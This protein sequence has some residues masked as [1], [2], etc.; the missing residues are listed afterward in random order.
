MPKAPKKPEF[1][2]SASRLKLYEGCSWQ[3]YAKYKLKLPDVSN[4]GSIRGSI[5][6]KI[7]EC[8]LRPRHR[9]HYDL[10]INSKNVE[11]SPQIV[12]LIQKLTKSYNLETVDKK[13]INNYDLI[14]EM[15]LVGLGYDFFC[16]RDD[17]LI[18]AEVEI[19]IDDKNYKLAGIV[20]KLAI[21]DNVYQI[22]DFKSSQ[23]IEKFDTQALA[24]ILWAKKVKK[25]DAVA[26]FI[27]LRFNDENCIQEYKFSDDILNG[28]ESYLKV[29]YKYL[30]N[31]TEEDA[32]SH[33]A[34][35]DGYPPE[36]G[37]FKGRLMCGYGKFKGH[38]KKTGEEYFVCPYKF[39]VDF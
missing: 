1:A 33:F 2:I 3:Y 13:G 16:E 35:D 29:M 4:P 22:Y 10:I 28:F 19:L 9:R 15:V 6:H 38:T 18:G 23:S 20:D 37:G 11:S 25:C 31:F 39:E 7:F 34:Y 21:K 36:D 17:K 24:Y 8:L 32:H 27:F 26:K 5:A 30:K 14:K 12:R